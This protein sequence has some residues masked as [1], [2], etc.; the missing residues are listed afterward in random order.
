MDER[1]RRRHRRMRQ[2]G[3]ILAK[4]PG[5]QHALVNH[6]S[7]RQAGNVENLPARNLA[8]IAYRIFR[9]LADDVKLALERQ[10]VGQ[11]RVTP[12]EHLAHERLG[13]PGGCAEG[14]IVRRHRAP[15]EHFLP[16][17]G[18]DVAKSFFA[19]EA[20]RFFVRQKD[21]PHAVFARTGQLHVGFL[22]NEFQ[23]MVRRLYENTRAVTG[24]GLATTRAA[25]IEIQQNLKCLT[26]D[27]V[28][29]YP[30]DIDNETNAAGF[31][32]E[33]RIIQALFGRGLGPHRPTHFLALFS[34]L[35]LFA[36]TFR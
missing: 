8:G 15:A 13:S 14:I 19:L 33:L 12:D 17:L 9:A 10:F 11:F 3:V 18:D 24:I 22:G 32:L 28:R 29:L 4:L 5:G 16:F 7:G 2:V 31:V 27:L 23:E 21:H 25:V 1:Q 36:P 34:V 26:D 6:R 30:L 20:L 35:H